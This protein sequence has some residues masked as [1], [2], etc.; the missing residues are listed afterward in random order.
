M[1]TQCPECK[2]EQDVPEQYIGK[3]IKCLKCQKPFL[4]SEH[5]LVVVPTSPPRP[6]SIKPTELPEPASGLSLK[7]LGGFAIV[8]GVLA[9]AGSESTIVL[10]V[11]VG[12]GFLLIGIGWIIDSLQDIFRILKQ[13]SEKLPKK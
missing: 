6:K 2:N 12:G 7:I 8:G 3:E 9:A 4:A 10:I 1:K 5:N 13:I 11:G